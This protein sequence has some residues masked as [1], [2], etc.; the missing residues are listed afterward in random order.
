MEGTRWAAVDA[1]LERRT[2]AAVLG[3]RILGLEQYLAAA[4]AE[5]G[6]LTALLTKEQAD[7]SALERPWARLR[8]GRAA[9]EHQLATERAERDAACLALH[10]ARRLAERLTAEVEQARGERDALGDVEAALTAALD[11]EL[12]ALPGDGPPGLAAAVAR[13]RDLR[14]QRAE[15]EEAWDVG[16]AAL[17][18]L[19]EPDE[20]LQAAR[21]W[22]PG[23]GLLS[24]LDTHH[25]L[26]DAADLLAEAAAW[27]Q[28]LRAEAG[29]VVD[30]DLPEVFT[31]VGMP[32]LQVWLDALAGSALDRRTDRARDAVAAAASAVDAALSALEARREELECLITAAVAAR[33]EI[34]AGWADQVR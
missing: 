11:A 28:R 19:T 3:A 10:S 26:Q 33:D 6:D 27:L 14:V 34:L 9:Y 2:R 15:A 32:V 23:M 17:G 16:A 7:V 25:E 30:V 31:A 29:D 22:G 24:A 21:F 13:L 12:A 4:H 1:A 18:A 5:I 8:R 20:M